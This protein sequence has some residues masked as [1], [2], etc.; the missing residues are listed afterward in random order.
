MYAITY[1]RGVEVT[2]LEL[3]VERWQYASKIGQIRVQK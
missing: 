2:V 3:G 1:E